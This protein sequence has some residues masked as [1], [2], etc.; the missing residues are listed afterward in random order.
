MSER[1][2]TFE[3]IAGEMERIASRIDNEDDNMLLFALAGH[4]RVLAMAR[5]ALAPQWISVE[6]RLPA[7]S[8]GVLF[9]TTDGTWESGYFRADYG[10]DV[11]WE[12]ERTGPQ[13][14]H[15]D[16]NEHQVTHWMIPAAPGRETKKV[17]TPN[18]NPEGTK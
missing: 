10:E 7:P 8:S 2:I 1:R 18:D 3:S 12:C 17:E 5:A 15:I 14:D 4:V 11:R 9:W 6:E 16:F 13:D